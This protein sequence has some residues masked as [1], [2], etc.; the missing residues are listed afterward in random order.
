MKNVI[1]I[2]KL[3]LPYRKWVA[4]NITFNF[5]GMLFSVFS[6]AMVIPL[7]RILFSDDAALAELAEQSVTFNYSEAGVSDWLNYYMASAVVDY[8]KTNV[9][10]GICIALVGMVLLK[11]LCLYISSLFLSYSVHTVSKDLRNKMYSKIV[12]LDLSYYSDER[13]GDI[14]SRFTAD[15]K[16][17]EFSVLASVDAIFKQPFYVIGYTVSIFLINVKLSLF[18]L[19]FLPVAGGIIAIL[20]KN[21][22]RN[23][24]AGQEEIGNMVSNVEETLGGA[25]VIK[26][27]GAEKKVE[28]K[29]VE[30]N[31]KIRNLMVKIFRVVDIASPSSEVLG[32][33]AT[34]GVLYYGGHLV[35]NGE[36]EADFLLGYLV[37]FSQLI[38][39]FKIISKATFEATRGSTAL[40]RIHEITDAEVKVRDAANPID[41]KTLEKE[42]S[43]N[44]VSFK[45]EEDLVL[46]NVDFT[47]PKGSTVALVG[48]SGSGKSTLAD[49]LPRFYDVVYGAIKIDGTDVRDIKKTSLRSMMGIVT[50]QS[51]LFNDTVFNNIAFGVDS[52]TYEEVINAAK[53]AN[54]HD[55]IMQLPNGY[56][57][58]IGDG[59]GKLSGGQKQRISIARA[60]LSDPQI[61][62]LDEATSALDTESEKLV[63]DALNNLMKS[64]TSLVIAHR[65]STIQHADEIIVMHKGEII[66]RGTHQSLIDANGT[67]KKLTEMQSFT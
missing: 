50:Q 8:G 45:Y 26:A 15:I 40:N 58:N 65:L 11:N 29:F 56:E 33:A 21:L 23:A 54:A 1:S 17:V 46:R 39:P 5:L 22:K 35:F 52:A 13:K 57:T 19:I 67:Y 51:I 43:F 62:I 47:I 53:V 14:L 38:N 28:T 48:Q 9:L 18:I 4:G 37:L 41:V 31:S 6:F 49:L 66:E 44:D 61:L 27:F 63:Q 42:V 3:L 2:I 12:S 36:L 24:R 20:N 30:H 25:K 34:A 64:R 10:I 59:G 32:V 60:V 7:L 16:D 55:F